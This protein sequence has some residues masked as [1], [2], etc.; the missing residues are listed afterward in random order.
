MR[1]YQEFPIRPQFGGLFF[2][3]LPS[4]KVI[5]GS[6]VFV[7]HCDLQ[8]MAV[9]FV[10]RQVELFQPSRVQRLIDGLRFVAL[11]GQSNTEIKYC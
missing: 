10:Q 8:L 5:F 2:V 11:I 3:K 7:P 6:L 4:H 9:V 1:P